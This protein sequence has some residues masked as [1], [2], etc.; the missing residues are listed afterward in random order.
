MKKLLFILMLYSV[1]AI[2]SSFPGPVAGAYYP[3]YNSGV[4]QYMPPTTSMPFNKVS[5][6]WV[7]FAHAYPKDQGALL[8]FEDTQPDEINRLPLLVKTA[9]EINPKIKILISLG[10]GHNDWSYIN[11]DY[12]NKANVFVDSVIHFIRTYHLDRFDIDDESINGSSGY[13]SQENFNG[14]IR[15]L[16]AALDKAGQEDSKHYYLTITPAFGRAQVDANNM[17][18]FDLIN[19]QNYGGSYPSDFTILGYPANQIV[20]GIDSEWSCSL[21]LPQTEGFAG[22]F[23]WTMSADSACQF[24]YT[25]KIADK[26]GYG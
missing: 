11:S 4:G 7:A 21:G 23:N 2:A 18:Y 6:L 16:R 24:T 25:N 1:N 10:W 19:T 22:I 15:N 8:D 26:V 5:L 12:E 9:Q 14:V 20:Q 17:N 13:I 3:I